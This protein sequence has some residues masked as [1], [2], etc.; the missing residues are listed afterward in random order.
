MASLHVSFNSSP[1]AHIS[2][3]DF[4]IESL[5]FQIPPR[6]IINRVRLLSSYVNVN[7]VT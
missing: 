4:Y 6:K 1:N 7:R 3:F 2:S 5:Y